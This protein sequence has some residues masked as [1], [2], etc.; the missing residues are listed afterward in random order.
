MEIAFKVDGISRLFAG[1]TATVWL[2][3]GIYSFSYMTHEEREHEF[4]GCYL[5]V[6]GVLIGLD[7][8]ANLITFIC[9]MRQ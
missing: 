3:V 2:L 6:L 7:F 1:L 4:F 5:I 9:F 8:S